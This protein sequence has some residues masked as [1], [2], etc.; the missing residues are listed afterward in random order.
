MA[1]YCMNC[2]HPIDEN[3]DVCLNC[4]VL[5]H[6]DNI[7]NNSK[8]KA[9]GQGMGI[10]SMILGIVAAIWTLLTLL[11]VGDLDLASSLGYDYTIIESIAFAIGF[12]LFSLT[13]SILGLI[14]SIISL[15]QHK[16]GFNISGIILN[17]ISL[18][19]TLIVFIYVVSK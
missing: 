7:N 6:K 15:K 14:F 17:S 16:S 1:K 10:A 4:G 11:A 2:G 8:V 3:A 12:T 9:P 13:P 19:I 5:I 18:F